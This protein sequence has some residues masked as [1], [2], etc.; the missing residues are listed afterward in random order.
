[1][2]VTVNG[3]PRDSFELAPEDDLWLGDLAPGRWVIDV[4]WHGEPV[5][6]SQS[7]K[8]DETEELHLVL[9][10]GALHGQT[11]EERKRAGR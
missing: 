5:L 9:P 2:E 8:L 4:N 10:D 1:V 3:A 6:R 7:L 11:E